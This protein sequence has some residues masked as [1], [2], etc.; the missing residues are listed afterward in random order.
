M[1]DEKRRSS[2]PGEGQRRRQGHLE[3]EGHNSD[4]WRGRPTMADGVSGVL[5][6]VVRDKPVGPARPAAPKPAGYAGAVR[7]AFSF[8]RSQN[9]SSARLFRRFRRAGPTVF[10]PFDTQYYYFYL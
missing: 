2:Q 4:V 9:F 5:V 8:L 6:L 7:R 3:E 10:D 1:V